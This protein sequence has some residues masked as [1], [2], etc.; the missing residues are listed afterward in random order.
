MK[1]LF[2]IPITLFLISIN[3]F[4]QNYKKVDEYRNKGY[5]NITRFS[6]INVNEAKLETFSPTNGVVVTEL[7]ID[8]AQAYSLQTINGYFFSPYFSAG[9]GAGLD[10]YHNPNINTVPVFLDLRLYLSNAIS[11]MYL[12]TD[13]GTLIEIKNGSK[14]GR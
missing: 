3:L 14:K 9:I 7:P 11:S 12:Y 5:F 10:G 2:I 13:F 8:Q 4:S 6:Y 1:K